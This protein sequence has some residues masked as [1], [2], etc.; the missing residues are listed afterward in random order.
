[1][2]SQR[3]CGSGGGRGAARGAG[4]GAVAVLGL[5]L[6]AL[7]AAGC[8]VRV[9]TTYG[10]AASEGAGSGG[11]KTGGQDGGGNTASGGQGG[12]VGTGGSPAGQSGSNGSGGNAGRGGAPVDGG[13][14]RPTDGGTGGMAGCPTCPSATP[15]CDMTTSKCV[16]CLQPG[17]CSAA[18]PVCDPMSHS[19]V[20]C[21]SNTDCMGTT[22]VC[23]TTGSHTCVGCLQHS[24]C[25]ATSTKPICNAMTKTCAGC[26][27]KMECAMATSA[28]PVC[29]SSD[30]SCVVCTEKADCA[31]MTATPVC[32][33]TDGKCVGC[34]AD[35]D[36]TAAKPICNTASHSC[37]ACTTNAQCMAKDANAPACVTTDGDKKGTCV[38]CTEHAQC[39]TAAK[40]VCVAN[41]CST[42]T[43]DAQCVAKAGAGPGVCMFHTDGHCATDA[44]VLYVKPATGCDDNGAGTATVPFC[45]PQ[46]AIASSTAT[47]NVV[48]IRKGTVPLVN[49]TFAGATPISVIGQGGATVGP[50]AGIGIEV[51]SGTVY[52]RGLGVSGMT[53]VG[54]SVAPNATIKLDGCIV[55]MNNGGLS[56]NGGGF[57]INNSVFA[58]NAAATTPAAFGG[59]YLKAGVGTPKQFRNNTIYA[60]A[61]PGLVC[62][63]MYPVRGLLVAN[64]AGGQ[65]TACDFADTSSVVAG[66]TIPNPFDTTRPYR[67]TTTSTVCVDLGNTMDFSTHDIDGNPRP[68][69]ANGRPDCG[70]HELQ[71]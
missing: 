49:W 53:G 45:T 40:P 1:M 7:L 24:Q 65:V 64:N 6:V 23:D 18:K 41:V 62:D 20:G 55:T 15:V 16:G 63:D 47:K 52:I 14:D 69:P 9:H 59:V 35:N 68:S 4:A 30:G 10:D 3:A 33:T 46:R 50:S 17:H 29:R 28:T 56:V 22:P 8:P 31:A 71:K 57:E 70:A 13:A 42:C 37:T 36:C 2:T 38:A 12:A 54:I 25:V 43:S 26:T 58:E 67:L 60:N 51:T 19:C 44:E 66:S 61:G 48:V 34:L 39:M 5:T 27:A 32:S 11:T 21:L